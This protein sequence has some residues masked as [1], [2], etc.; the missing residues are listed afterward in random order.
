MDLTNVIN[1]GD[2]II[3]HTIEKFNLPIFPGQNSSAVRWEE[4]GEGKP[5]HDLFA[6][7]PRNKDGERD[8]AIG[9]S[10]R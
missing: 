1:N 8:E 3:D 4:G 5:D 6:R 7:L 9:P 10:I 2:N